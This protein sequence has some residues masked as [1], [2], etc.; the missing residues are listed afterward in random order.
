MQEE[1]RGTY[2]RRIGEAVGVDQAGSTPVI[3]TE[4]KLPRGVMNVIR[5][6]DEQVFLRN[7]NRR[8]TL[9]QGRTAFPVK[10]LGGIRQRWPSLLMPGA[11]M[12]ARVCSCTDM[13]ALF[14][15]PPGDSHKRRRFV[16]H[17]RIWI[18]GVEFG[19][20]FSK[21]IYGCG[22]R[23]IG[24]TASMELEAFA[25]CMVYLRACVQSGLLELGETYPVRPGSSQ[26]TW[27]TTSASFPL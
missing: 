9:N 26:I 3:Y 21:T 2:R 16:L 6:R 12:R 17:T 14:D 8:S 13:L 20:T 22:G 25:Q 11:P 7:N 18:E 1:R 27:I 24:L 5:G 4:Y 10:T 19:I 15:H 23:T